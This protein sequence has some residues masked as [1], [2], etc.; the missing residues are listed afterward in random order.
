M[1]GS[2]IAVR[3]LLAALLISSA[4]PAAAQLTGLTAPATSTVGTGGNVTVGYEFQVGAFDLE[5]LSLGM[6]DQN[7]DGFAAE[8][9]VSLWEATL[10]PSAPLASVTLPAGVGST[11]IGEFRFADIT[12]ITLTAG[13]HYLVAFHA[14][15]DP[16]HFSSATAS[17]GPTFNEPYLS[18]VERVITSGTGFPTH[19]GITGTGWEANFQFQ[20]TAVPEP[21]SAALLGCCGVVAGLAWLRRRGARL[22]LR[23]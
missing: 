17:Q 11:L 14:L 3:A 12:P 20:L 6:W 15:G 8:H 16:L 21:S 2:R 9:V 4:R 7:G 19:D 23:S 1:R 5:V 18:F 13:G 10:L 22:R